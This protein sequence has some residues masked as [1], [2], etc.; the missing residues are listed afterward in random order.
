MYSATSTN[1]LVFD[2]PNILPKTF[3][4]YSVKS[5]RCLVGRCRAKWISPLPIYVIW[6]K[7][8]NGQNCIQ[9][10]NWIRLR[11]NYNDN[12]QM[13]PDILFFHLLY[14][15]LYY[16]YY[17]SIIMFF[18]TISFSRLIAPTFLRSMYSWSMTN[19]KEVNDNVN[20][21]GYPF[22][23]YFSFFILSIIVFSMLIPTYKFPRKYD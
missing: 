5:D 14:R 18:F 8:I 2:N 15:R 17:F 23:Q 16:N 21:L 1:S 10:G 13:N 20:P 6:S 22:N 9:I 12:N 3:N 7:D 11:K 19:V 4:W